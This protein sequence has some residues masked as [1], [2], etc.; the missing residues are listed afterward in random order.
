MSCCSATYIHTLSQFLYSCK[1]REGG[2]HILN[3]AHNVLMPGFDSLHQ[4][5]VSTLRLD[6]D[7]SFFLEEKSDTLVMTV[8]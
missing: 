2:S 6:S 1:V 5:V 3:P 4:T 8:P 7:I